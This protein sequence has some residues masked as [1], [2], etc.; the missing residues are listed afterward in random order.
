MYICIVI[1]MCEYEYLC[2]CILMYMYKHLN[3]YMCIIYRYDIYTIYAHIC[4]YIYTYSN[5]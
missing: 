1:Y 5:T 2:M 3:I 4:I